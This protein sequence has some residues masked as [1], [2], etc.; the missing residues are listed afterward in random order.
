MN[1]HV[2]IGRFG[3]KDKVSIPTSSQE[4]ATQ[5]EFVKANKRF[6]HGVGDA[7]HD[8][9]TLEIYPTEIG[10][11]LMIVAAHIHAADTRISRATESQDN[12]TREIRLVIPVSDPQPWNDATAVLQTML[13]FLTGDRWSFSFRLRPKGFESTV[14][15]KPLVYTKP[16][17]DGLSLFSGGLDSLIAAIN[18]LEDGKNPLFVSHAG[19]GAVSASQEVVFRYLESKYSKRAFRRLRIWMNFPHGIVEGS[20]SEDSTRG[21]SFLFFASAAFAASGFERSCRLQVPENGLIALNVPLDQLRLGSLST[22]TT[23]P[24]YIARWNQLLRTL[25]LPVMVENPYWDQTKGEM[26]ANCSNRNILQQLIPASLSCASPSKARWIGRGTEHCGYCLP[27]LIRRASLKTGLQKA[28]PTQYTIQ[29]LKAAPLKTSEA[30]GL[31]ARSFQFAI[32]RLKARP[33]LADLL[34]H[35]PGPLT[36]ESQDRQ[37][38]L[39]QVYLRGM[40]EVGKL[41]E[42]VVTKP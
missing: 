25:R 26:V 36:D 42:G 19:E 8:L 30:K 2:L 17:F 14:T 41:L 29:N 1:R 31:Q 7:L 16:R 4:K 32:N 34:I 37:A 3:A 18:S 13:N 28:D 40:M 38:R 24:F 11:D 21:R 22:R 10:V 33:S 27:C 20:A 15:Q 6:D 12:W 35:K 5:L 9:K 23:H 39:G